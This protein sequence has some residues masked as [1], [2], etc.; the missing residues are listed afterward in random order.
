MSQ[1]SRKNVITRYQTLQGMSNYF[2]SKRSFSAY[3][4]QNISSGKDSNPSLNSNI[5]EIFKMIIEES[6]I[7]PKSIDSF[8]S[9]KSLEIYIRKN[10]SNIDLI[11]KKIIESENLLDEGVLTYIIELVYNFFLQ[12]IIPFLINILSKN[13]D[14]SAISKIN[15]TLKH[16]IK[17]GGNS[18]RKII[19]D[20]LEHLIQKFVNENKTFKY[21][22]TKLAYIQ[23]FCIVLKSAPGVFYSNFIQNNNLKNFFKI[24]DNFKNSKQEIREIIGKIVIY[25]ISMVTNR[26]KDMRNNYPF[27][28]YIHA[29]SDYEKHL[30]E[31]HDVPNNINIFS[32]FCTILLA[33]YYSYPIFFKNQYLYT[34]LVKNIFKAKNTKNNSL[35][36]ELIYFFPFLYKMNKELFTEKYINFFLKFS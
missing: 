26:E 30:S 1:L 14:L 6:K 4:T 18:T 17:L 2:D 20:R 10:R 32:G 19:E 21:E 31:N 5:N 12:K 8:Q 23:F 27:A 24:L 28:I 9:I 3:F 16:L 13:I 22:S 35:K 36:I 15:L 29:Y 11:T 7:S 25:F 33:I 34:S